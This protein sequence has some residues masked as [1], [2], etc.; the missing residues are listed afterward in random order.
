MGVQIAQMAGG[1]ARKATHDQGHRSAQVAATAEAA[2]AAKKPQPG[3][4]T[5]AIASDHEEA[6]PSA[7]E[8]ERAEE[9]EGAE[10]A[11]HHEG[12]PREVAGVFQQ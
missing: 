12:G 1:V 10:E 11:V 6:P 3:A 7:E 5:L 9:A 4:I 2:K 8:A